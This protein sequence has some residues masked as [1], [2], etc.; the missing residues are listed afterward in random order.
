MNFIQRANIK[1]Y[2]Q[3]LFY[4]PEWLV[5]GVN[6]VC[7]LHCKMCDVGTGYT[8]SNFAVN[9]VGTHPLNMPLELIHRIMDDAAQHFPKVKIGYAFTEPL[10]Y[11]HLIDSLFYARDKKLST[12]ITTNALTLPRHADALCEAELSELFISLDGPE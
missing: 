2:P 12:A 8:E 6:N 9:L 1:L 11:P 7:N 4:G 3:R 10:A 5:L